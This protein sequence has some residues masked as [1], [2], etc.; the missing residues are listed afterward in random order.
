G[1]RSTASPYA[2][3]DQCPVPL[4]PEHGD[5]TAWRHSN[6]AVTSPS[7]GCTLLGPY[8]SS[9]AMWWMWKRSSYRRLKTFASCGA[10]RAWTTSRPRCTC[11]SKPQY[12]T[13]SRRRPESETGQPEC[14]S[15]AASTS[16]RTAGDSGLIEEKNGVAATTASA[17]ARAK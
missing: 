16:E 4:P 9:S 2:C 3:I 1:L 13:V 15:F 17:D 12:E 8:P 14:H 11:S 7:F 5:G 6:D 10:T